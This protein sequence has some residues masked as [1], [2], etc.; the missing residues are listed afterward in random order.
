MGHEC[1]SWRITITSTV[2]RGM[3]WDYMLAIIIMLAAFLFGGYVIWIENVVEPASVVPSPVVPGPVP[4]EPSMPGSA[5]EPP[6]EAS[7]PAGAPRASAQELFVT[8]RSAADQSEHGLV[9]NIASIIDPSALGQEAISIVR[10]LAR[11]AVIAGD[12]E[13][14]EAL[15]PI[16]T[17]YEGADERGRKL[18][19]LAVLSDQNE[20]VRWLVTS[21]LSS[22]DDRIAGSE[23]TPLHIAASAGSDRSIVELVGMGA[24]TLALSARGMTPLIHAA[25]VGS[26]AGVRDFLAAA[27]AFGAPEGL[28]F[29]DAE[30]NTALHAAARR[31]HTATALMLVQAGADRTARNNDGNRPCDVAL[32]ASHASLSGAIDPSR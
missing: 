5:N 28:A 7:Q 31:G 22:I 1:L 30:G 25:D 6:E 12:V 23:L 9:Y 14:L 24:D 18:I 16:G 17:A 10:D 26:H 2:R 32:R 8:L 3:A 20:V 15:R 13:M 19:H 21:R 11:R 29:R 27:Q 4:D